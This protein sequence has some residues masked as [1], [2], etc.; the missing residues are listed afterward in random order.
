MSTAAACTCDLTR[1]VTPDCPASAEHEAMTA[2]AAD[3]RRRAGGAA[4]GDPVMTATY[5]A[6]S[7]GSLHWVGAVARR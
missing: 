4:V 5:S 7:I 6:S 3:G 2:V 1:P